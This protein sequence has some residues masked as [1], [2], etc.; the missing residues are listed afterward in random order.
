MPRGERRRASVLLL[1]VD[2]C[3]DLPGKYL[4][5]NIAG[6]QVFLV[7]NGKKIWET[8]VQVG[9]PY[10]ATPVFK[11]TVRYL[12]FNP[13]WTVP[14]GILRNETLPAIR[15]DPNYL[16]R[17]NMSVVTHSGTI[18]D[19]SSIDWAATASKGFPHMIRQE[20]GPHNA[21]GRVKFMFP[22]QYMVY[23]HDTPSKGL[24][25]RSERA[26]SHG[27][28]R[29]ENPFDLAG[30]LLADQGWDRER[31]DQVVASKRNTRVNL[32]DPI[33]VMLLYWTAWADAE[34]T[35]SFRKDVYNRDP[36][37]IKGLETSRFDSACLR[38]RRRPSG[39]DNSGQSSSRNSDSS[40]HWS[41]IS[42]PSS[43]L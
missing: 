3:R 33:T 43:R 40:S 16:S 15:K 37:I 30:L 10:H 9:R 17:N 7:E 6:F 14:P 41:F 1:S 8:R 24:F 11:D 32:E 35:V 19:P 18:V 36:A 25:A 22:N 26:F 13:T 27:C 20:P 29:T 5:V 4:I 23:L 31:I 39:R 2:P 28:I 21:L 42:C 38:E 12:D 34:G